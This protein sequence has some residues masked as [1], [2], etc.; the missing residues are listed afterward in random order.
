[1]KE[2]KCY[3]VG[4]DLG[5]AMD[6]TALAVA[7]RQ[8]DGTAESVLPAHTRLEPRPPVYDVRHLER[9]G[10]SSSYPAV[11]DRL[12]AL[13]TTAPLAGSCVRLLVDDT[14]VGA[15][16]VDLLK[17]ARLGAYPVTVTITTGFTV[18]KDSYHY[19]VPKR[20]LISATKVLLQSERL[21]FAEGLP[22]T[23]TLVRELLAYQPKI[24]LRPGDS[25][26]A[27][28]EGVYD[29]LVLAV[30]MICWDGVT[31]YHGPRRPPTPGYD[32]WAPIR[33]RHKR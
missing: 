11:V 5:Q 25:L 26:A 10:L 22:E 9:F 20:D 32:V 28:R 19:V 24:D 12:R 7:E 30:A 1:M 29:D 4:L 6:Y 33:V 18:T 23:Q 31:N 27:W 2:A 13:L 15:P 3:Y 21:R 8:Q 17:H 14:G 16:V